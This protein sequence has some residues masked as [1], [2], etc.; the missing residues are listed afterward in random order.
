MGTIAAFAVPGYQASAG[1]HEYDSWVANQAYFPDGT[2][3]D[4]S[5]ST[6]VTL[7]ID[8]DVSENLTL[9]ALT[10]YSDF[11]FNQPQ[12]I[13]MHGGNF[14][15]NNINFEDVELL[16]QELRLASDY[17]GRFNFI[18]GLYYEEQDISLRKET[19][20]DGSLGGVFGQLPAQAL[21]PGL[22]P[23][24]L[25]EMG[26]NSLWN[27]SVLASLNPAYA[28]FAGIEHL[29]IYRMPGNDLR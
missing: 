23:V 18:A 6:N 12:D 27:G 17:E 28:P 9:T 3:L 14:G 19:Y 8:W 11:E 15:H 7:E 24:T 13:D 5:E 1:Q 29:S 25:S 2:D 26:I 4:Q 16:S 21:N 22:P 10:G 20:L